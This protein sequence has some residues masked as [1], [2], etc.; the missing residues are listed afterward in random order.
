M[1]MRILVFSDSHGD[2]DTCSFVMNRIPET[3]MIIHAGDHA[4]D[5]EK[6][7]QLFPKTDI[8]FVRGNCDYTA[9]PD[10]LSFEVSEKKF[11][12]SHGHLYNVKF[13]ADY[14]RLNEAALSE[15]SDIAVFG[16]THV[17]YYNN[18]G[19]IILLNPGSIKYGHTFG[20][21]EIDNNKLRADI[22]SSDMWL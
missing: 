13:D 17:P 16:H 10:K 1:S 14:K 15:N 9:A 20:I 18:S 7:R 19:K 12:L 22:C 4:A 5:A 21:I 3:D 2:T 6:L 8:K 11:F